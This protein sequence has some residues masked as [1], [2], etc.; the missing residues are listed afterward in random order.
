MLPDDPR[1]I[2]ALMEQ[3]RDLGCYITISKRDGAVIV[4]DHAEPQ[5][6][7]R[8]SSVQHL[9]VLVGVVERSRHRSPL[10]KV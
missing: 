3:L 7:V 2:K 1:Q 6:T 8:A 10:L 5:W 4:S 9:A